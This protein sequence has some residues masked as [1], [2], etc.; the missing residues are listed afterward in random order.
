M[1]KTLGKAVLVVGCFFSCATFA[2]VEET[3]PTI[4]VRNTY[5]PLN[6]F[7]W[8]F[9]EY[10]TYAG[11]AA[12]QTAGSAYSNYRAAEAKKK[13]RAE[14]NAKADTAQKTCEGAYNELEGICAGVNGVLGGLAAAGAKT[15]FSKIGASVTDELSTTISTGATLAGV[16]IDDS[17]VPCSMLTAEAMN[18]CASGAAKM[19]SKCNF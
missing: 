19:K 5:E 16:T 4:G 18:Y 1:E 13:A 9:S 14:C 10:G 6:F 8:H 2:D 3:P 11:G 15:F 17:L 7:D 12:S